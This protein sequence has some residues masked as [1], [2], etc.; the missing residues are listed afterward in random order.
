MFCLVHA[1]EDEVPKEPNMTGMLPSVNN[2]QQ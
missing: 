2:R 1:G